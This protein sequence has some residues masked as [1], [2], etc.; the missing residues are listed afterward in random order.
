MEKHPLKGLRVLDFTWMLAGPYVTRILADFGAEVIKVQC[1]KMAKGAE[2][3]LGGYFTT[4]NRSKRGITLDMS[5]PEAREIALRLAKISDVVIENF[6]PR[7]MPNWGLDYTRLKEVKPDLIVVSMSAMGQSG[8]WKNSVAYGATIQAL[9]G[10]TYLSSSSKET[11]S[12]LGYAYADII[13]SLYSAL[14]V[15]AALEFRDKTGKGQYIDISEYEAM[16]TLMGP[17]LM[18]ASM[19]QHEILPEGNLADHISAAPYGCYTCLGEDQWC[20]IAVFYETQWQTLCSVMGS[21]SWTQQKRF[22]TLSKRREHAQELDELIEQWTITHTSKDIVRLLQEAGV[23]A[24][25]VQNAE[26]MAE[27]PQLMARD[28][29]VSIEHP[30]LGMTMSDTY[31]VHLNSDVSAGWKTSPVLGEDNQ[32]V[33]MDLL[34]IKEDELSSYIEKGIIG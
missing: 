32:Y 25:I 17:S 20:V 34:G 23:P 1:K 9:S 4:W 16:C 8:P 7:V 14:A 13:A 3:N 15:L 2:S 28:Y 27:D 22:S 21:P 18:D 30:I 11:P 26:D 31:P 10:I 12:G 24:G 29:F 5:Y 19:N 6:S 33:F